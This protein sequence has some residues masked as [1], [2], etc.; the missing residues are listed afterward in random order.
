MEERGAFSSRAPSRRAAAAESADAAA[1]AAGRSVA[2]PSPPPP[3]GGPRRRAAAPQSRPHRAHSRTAISARERDSVCVWMEGCRHA[4]GAPALPC[5]FLASGTSQKRVKQPHRER[6]RRLSPPK[7]AVATSPETPERESTRQ[8]ADKNRFKF[9]LPSWRALYPRRP[10]P[11]C[12]P[13]RKS[14]RRGAGNAGSRC[15]AVHPGLTAGSRS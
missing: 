6:R 15:S 14:R 10:F 4:A 13:T 8:T 11:L 9:F 2:T 3:R 1:S 5:R 7:S 12:L